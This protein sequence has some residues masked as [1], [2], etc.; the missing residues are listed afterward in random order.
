MQEELVNLVKVSL[1]KTQ[2]L[3]NPL[4]K[5]DIMSKTSGVLSPYPNNGKK[6]IVAVGRYSYQKGFD[7]LIKAFALI[8]QKRDD[9]DLYIVGD[10]NADSGAIFSA[11]KQMAL[12]YNILSSVYQVGYQKN[13]Y[14]YIKFAD[15][16]VLSSRWEGL[17]NVLIES[18]FLGTPAA[19]F[20][21]VPVV[22]R[23][24]VEGRNGYLAQ[25]E[26][27]RSLSQA[28][29]SA[30]ELGRIK[31]SYVGSQLSDFVKLFS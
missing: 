29:V 16:F 8:C 9:V 18:Q 20:K 19:A 24:V 12:Q 10:Y 27:A 23:I 13:P 1:K 28:I 3:Q 15:C 21:C 17:P 26:D 7:L 14:P 11:I 31:S 22:E 2:V 6:H 30:I 25:K 4:D 5:E